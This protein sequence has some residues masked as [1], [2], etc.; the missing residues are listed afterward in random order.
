[1]SILI[2]AVINNMIIN[3]EQFIGAK[4]LT[5]L[6]QNE[7]DYHTHHLSTCSNKAMS[8]KPE[9]EQNWTKIAVL[10]KK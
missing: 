7:Q 6:I 2:K 9:L 10:H 4:K 8:L 1:M 3:L 5:T